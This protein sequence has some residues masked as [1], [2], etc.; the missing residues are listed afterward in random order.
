MGDWYSYSYIGEI[1][2]TSA[3]L[4]IFHEPVFMEQTIW[5]I[6]LVEYVHGI[7]YTAIV[8]L[9]SGYFRQVF[10]FQLT[11]RGLGEEDRTFTCIRL[12]LA[13]VGG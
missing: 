11:R 2:Q 5:Y 4:P 10:E 13:A 12:H 8:L 3:G 6:R 7:L 1:K 9:F